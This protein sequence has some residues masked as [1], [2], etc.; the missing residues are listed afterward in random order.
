MRRFSITIA[1]IGIVAL[2]LVLATACDS[3]PTDPQGQPVVLWIGAGLPAAI[4]PAPLNVFSLRLVVEGV[5]LGNDGESEC[6]DCDDGEDDAAPTL[7]NVPVDGGTVTLQ[8]DDVAPGTYGWAEIDL[9]RPTAAI[10]A[11]NPGWTAGAS[12]EVAGYY[13]GTPFT[14]ALPIE[15]ELRQVLEPAVSVGAAG[16]GTVTIVLVLPLAAWFQ[17]DGAVLDPNDPAQRARIE[18]NV[19]ASIVPPDET[20]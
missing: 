15:G 8:A 13:A 9:V 20:D 17:S 10:L 12:I 16:E 18:A 5:D 1:A 14:L 6:E 11:A 19:R 2:P 3:S 4:S 7:V